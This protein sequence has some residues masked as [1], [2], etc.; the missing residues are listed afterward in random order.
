MGSADLGDDA[1]GGLGA[2]RQALDLAK[3][4]HAHLEYEHLRVSGSGQDGKGQSDQAVEIAGRGMH[5]IALGEA[6][7]EHVL[8]CGLADRTRDADDRAAQAR[9]IALGQAQEEL[10]RIVGDEDGRTMFE[11][12]IDKLT[13][14]L[15]RHDD[16]TRAG[17]DGRRGERV[18]VDALTGERDEHGVGGNRAR[19]DLDTAANPIRIARHEAGTRGALKVLDCNLHH[20]WQPF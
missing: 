16:S 13:R 17:L 9:A 12:K 8:G 6:C 14:G 1:K 4:A 11:R 7:G 5:A 3:I 20:G 2:P 19:I 10:G 15:A 18:A